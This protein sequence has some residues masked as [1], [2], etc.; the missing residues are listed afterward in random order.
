MKPF[1]RK[2][3]IVLPALM[4]G[5]ASQAQNL[6][7]LNLSDPLSYS[8]D[9]GSVNSGQWSVAGEFCSLTTATVT[10]PGN[11]SVDPPMIAP[12]SVSA[13]STGN[14]GCS[15]L[16]SE[17]IYILYSINGGPWFTQ[18]IITGCELQV[19]NSITSGFKLYAPAGSSVQVMVRVATGKGS[20]KIRVMSGDITIGPAAVATPANW[21]KRVSATTPAA[22]QS[23]ALVFPNP[24]NG[25]HLNLSLPGTEAGEGVDVLIADMQGR[26]VYSGKSETAGGNVRLDLD[27]AQQLAPGIYAINVT[28]GGKVHRQLFTVKNQD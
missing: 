3:A 14:I 24:G 15:E 20:T 2:L 16:L 10:Y 6:Y 1:L 27:A 26:T 5:I 4:S 23:R 9:C 11:P 7:T 21:T 28:A 22:S 13:K 8:T 25:S 19:S 17:G 12:V 18:Q